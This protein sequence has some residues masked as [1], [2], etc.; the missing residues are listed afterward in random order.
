MDVLTYPKKAVALEYR[1]LSLP[2][3]LVE[4]QVVTRLLEQDSVVRLSYERALGSLDE[5]VGRLLGDADLERRGT[6]LRR[7]TEVLERAVT[8]EQEAAQK[9]AEAQE[10]LQQGSQA[11]RERRAAASKKAA[12]RT[13]QALEQEKA[14]KARIAE[15]TD[16]REQAEKSRIEAQEK[17]RAKAADDARRAEKA[18]IAAA[19]KAVTAAPAAQLEDALEEQATSDAQRDKA[20]TLAALAAKENENRA[21]E[22]RARS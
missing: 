15:E 9:A 8:L 10:S 4:T 2:A 14:D 21:A 16:A 12:R 5:T 3:R 19:E 18:R 22:R 13:T 11:A 17:A 7:R 20:D 1:A 6:A